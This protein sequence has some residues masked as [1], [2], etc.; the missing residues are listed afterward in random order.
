MGWSYLR[1]VFLLKH[2]S[3]FLPFMSILLASSASLPVTSFLLV[4]NL[5]FT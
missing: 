5:I 1:N 2:E 3:G 4:G